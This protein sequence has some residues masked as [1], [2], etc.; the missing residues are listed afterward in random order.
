[1]TKLSM[2]DC[3]KD[4]PRSNFT[5]AERVAAIRSRSAVAELS[6]TEVEQATDLGLV[7]RPWAVVSSLGYHKLNWGSQNETWSRRFD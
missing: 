5:A 1:M 4:T 7:Q 2:A 6:I 3:H